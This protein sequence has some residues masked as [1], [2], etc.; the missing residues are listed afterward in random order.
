ML[1]QAEPVTEEMRAAKLL[2]PDK[3]YRDWLWAH[4]EKQLAESKR[5]R[6]ARSVS[7]CHRPY[8]K[9]YTSPTK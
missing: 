9:P 6:E 4:R 7:L 8:K 2:L 5:I 3:T 1:S